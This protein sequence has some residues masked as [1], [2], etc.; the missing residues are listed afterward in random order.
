MDRVQLEPAGH[1]ED[2]LGQEQLHDPALPQLLSRPMRAGHPLHPRLL[3]V[4]VLYA[5]V[6]V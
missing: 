5:I 4:Y 3:D 6:Q 2:V 1:E